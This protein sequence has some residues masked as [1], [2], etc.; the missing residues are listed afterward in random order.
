MDNI[1]DNLSEKVFVVDTDRRITYVNEALLHSCGL[2]RDE[3]VGKRCTD[4]PH[5]HSIDETNGPCPHKESIDLGRP[6]VRRFINKMPDGSK[7]VIEVSVSPLHDD[8][9]VTGAASVIRNVT[10]SVKIEE[11][12]ERYAEGLT[13]LHE[14]ST[15]F[16]TTSSSHQALGQALANIASYYNADFTLVQVPGAEKGTLEV[17]GG[18]GWEPGDLDAPAIKMDP[19][20]MEGYAMLERCPVIVG[21]FGRET[22]FKRSE[23]LTAR[24]VMSGLVVPMVA[25]ERPI[26]VLNIFYKEPKDIDTAELW[27]LNVAANALGVY[28]QK[29]RSL[30]KLQKSEAFVSSVLEAI[31][32]GVVVVDRNYRIMTANKEYLKIIGMENEDVIGQYCYTVSH[33]LDKPC[34]EMGESCTVKHVFETGNQAT[35]LHTHY[36]KDG[37]PVYVETH[38][39]PVTDAFGSV[40]AA[41]ETVMDVTEKVTLERDL[42]RRVKELEEFYDMAVGR[43]LRMIEL[44]DE[45]EQL[46]AELQV[47]RKQK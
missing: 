8:G 34:F 6:V 24:G 14:I 25:D 4:L 41:V 17:A 32:E 12:L 7:E 18:T 47:Y 40:T 43:E 45:I 29:E 38:A 22:R 37:T 42:E 23:I 2:K 16:L 11:I 36:H 28:L 46:K 35:A 27:Y 21:D 3:L 33:L 30:E 1:L 39:Y 19:Q 26:G 20:Y 44:K 13:V 5:C 9:K 10:E 31:G 15:V